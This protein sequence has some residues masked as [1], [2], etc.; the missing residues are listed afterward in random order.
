MLK[1]HGDYTVLIVE[2]IKLTKT[3]QGQINRAKNDNGL[4]LD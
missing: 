3:C 4:Y 2:V 1:E